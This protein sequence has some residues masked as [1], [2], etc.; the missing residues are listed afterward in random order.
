MKS[1]S[2]AVLPIRNFDRTPY[3]QHQA[4]T[5]ARIDGDGRPWVTFDGSNAV[6]VLARFAMDPA[7]LMQ[8]DRTALAGTS[9]LLVFEDSDPRR[10]IVVSFIS[11]A[12]PKQAPPPATSEAAEDSR[13]LLVNERRFVINA[14]DEI[15]LR[16][17]KSRIV[18]Q[19]DGKILIKGTDLVSRSSGPNRIRGGNISLN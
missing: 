5:L 4:G 1:D 18:M 19:K 13:E 3:A 6:E 16:C 2:P 17:G 14:H 8:V 11:E 9:V 10:P 12:L 7:Q 15:E